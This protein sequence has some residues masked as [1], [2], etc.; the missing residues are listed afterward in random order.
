MAHVVACPKDPA[1][2]RAW[3]RYNLDRMRWALPILM[4]LVCAPSFAEKP[5]PQPIVLQDGAGVADGRLKGKQQRT[6]SITTAGQSL[7]LEMTA[8]P[9]RSISIE[10][11]DPEGLRLYLA[12]ESAGRWTAP[13]SKSGAYEIAVVRTIPTAPPSA[14][15][16]RITVR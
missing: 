15:R 6:Y 10:V 8:E 2:F 5:K 12:K 13:L 14:Y 1:A 4:A 9:M 3:R 11:Y 16:L 7:T